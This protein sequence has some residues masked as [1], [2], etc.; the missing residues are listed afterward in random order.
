MHLAT[1]D[2]IRPV[3]SDRRSLNSS[4]HS[5]YN[6]TASWLADRGKRPAGV[7]VLC[8]RIGAVCD[9]ACSLLTQLGFAC[10]LVLV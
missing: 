3:P 8:V 6:S 10:A 4:F 5:R 1:T 7:S 9:V 2:I